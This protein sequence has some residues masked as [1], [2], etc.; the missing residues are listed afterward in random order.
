MH[1]QSGLWIFLV[2]NID[3]ELVGAFGARED[4]DTAAKEYLTSGNASKSINGTQLDGG[5]C[6][7]NFDQVDTETG[8]A[9]WSWY[10]KNG[11][12]TIEMTKLQ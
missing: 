8:C 12:V 7:K 1:N 5:E 11:E 10:N 9:F 4:A 3:H 6:K 2:Y